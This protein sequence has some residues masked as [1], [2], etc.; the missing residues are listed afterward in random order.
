MI[1]RLELSKHTTKHSAWCSIER[2][3]YDITRYLNE[4]PGGEDIL[5]RIA[6]SD[7]TGAF[8]QVHPW[9]NYEVLL[10]GCFIG[11]LID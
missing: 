5:L 4:H 2:K 11:L 3:V 7:A 10:D 8:F 9:I 6:G 1:T